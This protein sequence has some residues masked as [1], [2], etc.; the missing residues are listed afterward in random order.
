MKELL[1]FF[2]NIVTF[3][4]SKTVFLP[5]V[6]SYYTAKVSNEIEII[7]KN[8]SEVYESASITKLLAVLT[9]TEYIINF[10][11]TVTVS[12]FD[13]NGVGCLN[14]FVKPG[15]IIS[16]NDLY[17]VILIKSD[18]AAAKALARSIGY[19]INHDAQDDNEAYRAFCCKMAEKAKKISMTYSSNFVQSW[20]NMKSST[21]DLVKLLIY[22]HKNAPVITDIWV[23]S[24]YIVK[25]TGI[26]ERTYHIASTATSLARRIVPE[27]IG[28]KTGRGKKY[29][30]WAFIW[31]NENDNELYATALLDVFAYGFDLRWVGARRIIDEVYN[32]KK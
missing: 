17:H 23:K 2:C 1:R 24:E 9:A 6:K 18:N 19:K 32:L 21:E 20:T 5:K 22:V 3:V 30:G 13:V 11:E 8:K 27:Y 10:N 12:E 25:I 16:F 28:G 15:D 7:S 14:E 29:G 4:L 31:E 26:N